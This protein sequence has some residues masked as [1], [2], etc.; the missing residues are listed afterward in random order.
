MKKFRHVGQEI[1]K[2]EKML[3]RILDK[4][5]MLA[6]KTG[7]L[8]FS[9]FIVNERIKLAETLSA[10]A[11]TSADLYPSFQKE[12]KKRTSHL[13]SKIKK[14]DKAKDV[15]VSD[16]YLLE[17]KKNDLLMLTTKLEEA[18]EEISQK[19]QELL[20]QQQMIGEQ[21]QKLNAVHEEM[22]AKNEELERQKDSLMDQS[23]YLH[24][25]NQTIS[26]MHREVEMQKDEILR[27]NEELLILNNEKNNLIGIVAH[28]LKSPL[29]QIRGL[30]SLMKHSLTD[31]PAETLQYIEM[32][33][34]S[35]ERL[36]DMIGKILDVE[37]IES[38]SLNLVMESTDLTKILE[39]LSNRYALAAH[40][41]QIEICRNFTDGVS[42]CVDRGY[43]EQVLENLISNAIKF[44][45]LEK[46]VY[47]IL[48]RDN[49]RAI[50]EIRDEGP[51]LTEGD[52]K[53]LFGKYQKLSAR[54]TGNET[55]TGLGLSIVKKFV[56]AMNGR[57]WCES[58]AGKGASFFVSFPL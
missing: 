50:C 39:G 4:A 46:R 41:K 22:I 18:Y 20:L 30:L 13:E 54:P 42:A 1:K 40:Q 12:L 7:D 21:A 37:A 33:E 51:G 27:K 34:G 32:M 3:G 35:S 9:K 25:A 28:D 57:I 19:N 58:E 10:L 55:S 49:E 29:N 48:S 38:K 43:A 36:S 15:L 26:N 2:H 11:S 8:K 6:E 5:A 23:D 56:E 16:N 53:K 24:E 31:L 52:K 45:P 14:L 17:Y 47:I 44:S